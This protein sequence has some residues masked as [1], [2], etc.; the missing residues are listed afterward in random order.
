MSEYEDPVDAVSKDAAVVEWLRDEL[1]RQ[2]ASADDPCVDNE[3]VANTNVPSQIEKY[4]QQVTK[5]CCG[6]HDVTVLCPVD[7]N[8]YK[9]G[10]NYGH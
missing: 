10:F 3:R 8:T 1:Q 7:G 9:I 2:I 5:G 6:F 4:E